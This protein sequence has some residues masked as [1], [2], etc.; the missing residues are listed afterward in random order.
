M[1]ET[2]CPPF[3]EDSFAFYCRNGK[4]REPG[5]KQ[6]ES[7]LCLYNISFTSIFPPLIA[8][9]VTL[10]MRIAVRDEGGNTQHNGHV[11]ILMGNACLLASLKY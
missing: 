2:K 10:K 8:C 1:R 5:E 7:S 9:K 11:Q 4:K 3:L 6:K